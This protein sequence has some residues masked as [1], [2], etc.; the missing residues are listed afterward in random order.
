VR[1]QQI[2]IIIDI[3]Y[4]TGDPSPFLDVPEVEMVANSQLSDLTLRLPLL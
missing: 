1:E 2:S 4:A 3:S